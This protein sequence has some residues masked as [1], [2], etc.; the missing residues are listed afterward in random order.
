VDP[1]VAEWRDVLFAAVGKPSPDLQLAGLVGLAEC[2]FGRVEDDRCNLAAPLLPG[3][4]A[5][6]PI[7]EDLVLPGALAE[8]N[9]TVVLDL[10]GG[11]QQDQARVGI[12]GVDPPAER[13]AS[14][15]GVILL[16]I[17]AEEREAE[18]SLALEGAMA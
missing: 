6:D 8:P 2:I 5:D 16:G 9:P 10:A 7:A 15:R 18:A 13:L 11:L 12:G 1:V 14:Q 17:V 4:A 3:G